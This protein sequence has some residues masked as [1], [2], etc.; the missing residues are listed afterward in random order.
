MPAGQ[1][2]PTEEILLGLESEYRDAY[3]DHQADEAL[4]LVAWLHL[5]GRRYRRYP[6]TA[7]RLGSDS[8]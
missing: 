4:E 8:W 1:A 5:A 3:E 7:R 6:D 2:E